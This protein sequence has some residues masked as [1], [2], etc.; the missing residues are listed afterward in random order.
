MEP[1]HNLAS[2]AFAWAPTG[3]SG[4]PLPRNWAEPSWSLPSRQKPVTWVERGR[5]GDG[6]DEGKRDDSQWRQGVSPLGSKR[7]A[8]RWSQ[9]A[10][11]NHSGWET[12]RDW[13]GASACAGPT[14]CPPGWGGVATSSDS[15][16]SKKFCMYAQ[17]WRLIHKCEIFTNNHLHQFKMS[18]ML[19][20]MALPDTPQT[21]WHWRAGSYHGRVRGTCCRR[22]PRSSTGH[23]LERGGGC[24]AESRLTNLTFQLK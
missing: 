20:T 14:C 23:T 6:R 3:G 21:G 24:T 1:R 17:T 12:A 4:N 9:P 13:P 2:T 5:R 22:L 8:P 11:S 18:K 7:E 19:F 10:S 15:T 16:V